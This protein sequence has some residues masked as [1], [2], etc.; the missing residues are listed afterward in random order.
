MINNIILID[1]DPDELMIFR[2]AVDVID[3][4]IQ[5]HPVATTHELDACVSVHRPDLIFLDINMHVLDGF[6]WL[7]ML[8]QK[9]YHFPVVM[10]SNSSDKKDIENSYRGGAMLYLVKPVSFLDLVKCL[11]SIFAL[12]LK[13][14]SLIQQKYYEN[15]YGKSFK[16]RQ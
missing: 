16:P 4:T 11:E 2:E 10:Y 5:L 12:D 8:K 14:P 7:N 9:G 13:D 3:S 15:G 6:G 1:D